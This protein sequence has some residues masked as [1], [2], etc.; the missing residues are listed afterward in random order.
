MQRTRRLMLHG[1][2]NARDLGGFPTADG[3]CTRFGVFVRSEAPCELPHEDVEA[4][5]AYGVRCTVDLRSTDES[6][7][8]PSSLKDAATYVHLP[9][10][11]EAAVYGAKPKRP[12][13]QPGARFDWGRLYCEMAEQSRDWAARVL[14]TLADASGA[15]LYHCTTGKDRTGLLT[16]YLLSIAGVPRED[17]AADYCVSELFLQPVYERLRAGLVRV[18]PNVAD[19]TADDAF[20]HTP[21]AAML[22]L[23]DTMTARYGSVTAFLR[24]CGVTDGTFEQIRAKLLAN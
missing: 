7:A 24:A 16:C 10:F 23:I 19:H 18:H 6:R 2:H 8:R 3:G 14:E 4:I 17:I 11:S 5:L 22:T 13:P 21:A 1:L 12:A 9:L 20:F 15:V